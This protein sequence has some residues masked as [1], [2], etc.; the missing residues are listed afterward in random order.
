MTG[1]GPGLGL[2]WSLTLLLASEPHLLNWVLACQFSI[3]SKS[4]GAWEVSAGKQGHCFTRVGLHSPPGW[5]HCR[6]SGLARWTEERVLSSLPQ[7]G[8][9]LPDT[10]LQPALSPDCGCDLGLCLQSP[11]PQFSHL[12]NGRVQTHGRPSG[13]GAPAVSGF[14]WAS[15]EVICGLFAGSLELL[16]L[17]GS[18]V[19]C[20]LCF[21]DGETRDPRGPEPC[22]RLHSELAAG[23]GG[24]TPASCQLLRDLCG[25]GVT[26]TGH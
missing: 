7:L 15:L 8:S 16:G 10:W 19:P 26:V 18:L 17:W 23:P 9:S 5:S 20:P 24:E 14:L 1:V 3:F 21:R 12:Q 22:P 6:Y 2:G 4:E 25:Q 11:R 13:L